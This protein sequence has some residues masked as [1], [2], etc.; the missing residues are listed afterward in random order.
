[1]PSSTSRPLFKFPNSVFIWRY[2]Q[3]PKQFSFFMEI[4]SCL[5][6]TSLAPSVAVPTSLSYQT[7]NCKSFLMTTSC[8]LNCHFQKQRHKIFELYSKRMNIYTVRRKT[9]VQPRTGNEGREGR[10]WTDNRFTLSLSSAL[11]GGRWLG[12][13][14]GSLTSGRDNRYPFISV[15]GWAQGAGW[16][17]AENLAPT[18]IRSPDRPA[19]NESLYRLSCSSSQ[20]SV[21]AV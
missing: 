7:A 20:V 3:S 13:C 18:G 9:E 2:F 8:N 10:M 5:C 6:Q 21:C 11:D 15:W 1:M 12:R 19:L 4:P 16:T 14:C 17:G